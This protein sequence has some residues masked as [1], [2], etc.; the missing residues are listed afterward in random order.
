MTM[1]LTPTTPIASATSAGA[2]LLDAAR[3][4]GPEIEARAGEAEAA[5]TVPTDLVERLRGAGLLRIA[6]A[7]ALGGAE[8]A[9]TEILAI[10]EELCRADGSIGWTAM[11]GNGGAAFASWLDPAVARDLLGTDA[12]F[13]SA[14]VFAPLGR[15]MARDDGTI[16]LEGRWPWASGCKHAEWFVNGLF[17]F[18]GDAPRMVPDH[19][20]DWRLAWI[21]AADVEV[22]DNWDVAGMAATGSHDVAVTGIVVDDDHTIAPFRE[23]AR[24]DGALWRLPFFTLIG[25]CMAGVPLGI[26][27]R[28]LDEVAGSAMARTRA[29][30]FEPVGN[31]PVFQLDLAVAE[32]GV[33]AARALVVDALDDL[34]TT[35]CAGDV[36]SLAQRA[37]L[38]LAT[39]Q[40]K[41]AGTAA[42]DT[43]F[44]LGGAGA[45]R[46]TSPLQ[47]CL[48]DIHVV[49]QHIYFADMAS[50]RFA[51]ATLGIEQPTAHL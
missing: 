39:Q 16:A 44:A 18:D 8:L 37:R 31:D 51:M 28:A 2:E 4:L 50:R 11:I 45:A 47:R 26:A 21:R 22:I 6:Q 34:W 5:G 33:Q 42:V 35:A 24:Q 49:G 17:V 1:M 29:G 19:G 7:R 40:A 38:Q 41:R 15:G 10:V 48:R 32:G 20:P 12:D 13:T 25:T 27:R 23:A 46:A 14:S 30:S 9:P 36:P 3:A 43:A